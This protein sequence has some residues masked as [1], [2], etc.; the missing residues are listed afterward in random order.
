MNCSCCNL[1]LKEEQPKATLMCGHLIHTSCFIINIM[2][3]DIERISCLECEERIVTPTLYAIVYPP[4]Q[5]P[6]IKLHETSEEFRN[7]T[8]KLILNYKIFTKSE[9]KFKKK[10][11]PIINEFKLNVK[12]QITILKNY[13]KSKK[14]CIKELEEYSDSLKKK[15][16]FNRLFNKILAKYNISSYEFRKYLR[17][18]KHTIIQIRYSLISKIDRKFRIRI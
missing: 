7:T 2:R 14:K 3:S 18:Y 1:V 12:P 16:T 17:R 13:I 6:C 15:N 11:A 9:S 4:S 10:L 8:D 5:D